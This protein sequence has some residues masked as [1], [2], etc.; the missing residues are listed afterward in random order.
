MKKK[1][2]IIGAGAQGNVISG[3]LGKA[4]DV[5]SITLGDI[6]VA[7]ARE[8]AEFVNPGKIEAALIDAAN[9]EEMTSLMKS[10]GYDLV[11]NATLTNFNRRIIQAA[12][13]AKTN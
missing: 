10:G 7:R 5:G 1:I 9:V 4:E 6:D 13:D 8:V 2:L 3:V 11:V 12:V